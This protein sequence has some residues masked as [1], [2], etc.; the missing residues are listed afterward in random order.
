MEG[1]FSPSDQGLTTLVGDESSLS[2]VN[3]AYLHYDGESV[4]NSS[5]KGVATG[6]YL[7]EKGW[8]RLSDQN[9]DEWDLESLAG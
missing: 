8:F 7:E 1:S 4:S 3:E 9:I 5:I 2:S 6:D